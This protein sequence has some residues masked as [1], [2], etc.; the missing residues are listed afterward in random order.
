MFFLVMH[1]QHLSGTY[2]QVKAAV[3]NSY[4]ALKSGGVLLATCTGISQISRYD[5]DR[6]G[7]YWRLTDA[8]AR[9][10][11]GD[12]FGIGNVSIATYGNVRSATAYLQGLA[13]EDLTEKE[14]EYRDRDYQVVIAVRAVKTTGRHSAQSGV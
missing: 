14:L 7:D 10:L 5:M 9:R 8:S 2:R 1:R 3:A 12:V 13:A 4:A 6:W 11:F